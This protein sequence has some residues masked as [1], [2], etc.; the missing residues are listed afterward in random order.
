MDRAVLQRILGK[1]LMVYDRHLQK[2]EAFDRAAYLMSAYPGTAEEKL[3]AAVEEISQ[4][5]NTVVYDESGR[6]SIMVRVTME[7]G[8]GSQPVRVGKYQSCLFEG[9]LCSL[10]M[11]QPVSGLSYGQALQLSRSKGDGWINMPLL[12]R[13]QIAMECRRKGFLPN[14]ANDEGEDYFH[15]YEKGIL[16][17]DRTVLTGSGPETWAHDGT[18][19]GI[20]DMNGNVNEWDSGFRLVD[21]E[22]QFI[23]LSRIFEGS[24]DPGPDSP[25]WKALLETGAFTEPGDSEALKF[26][27]RRNVIVLAKEVTEHGLGN[28]GFAEIMA[29]KGIRVPELL[30]SNGLY[31][32]EDRNNYGHGW[33]WIS[34]E[35]EVYPVCGGA[36][37]ATYHAGVFFVGISRG[38]E[39]PYHL[40]GCRLAYKG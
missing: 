15:P 10:P 3:K 33:R 27:I 21:G 23:P 16:C 36:K 32:E 37:W 17:E 19:S 26:D 39:E 6:P 18:P 7:D 34:T 29:V 35:G 1:E 22:L 13:M 9:G 24:A 12:L 4:R 28:C 5:K 2:E 30:R 14:G 20:Y 25:E 11:E 38:G 31:P 8:A 40:G